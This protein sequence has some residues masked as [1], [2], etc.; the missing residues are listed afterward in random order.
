MRKPKKGEVK[1]YK[2][3]CVASY[4][5]ENAEVAEYAPNVEDFYYSDH[6]GVWYLVFK[7]GEDMEFDTKQEMMDWI[8][9]DSS[10]I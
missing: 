6:I 5:Q 3:S 4:E 10:G 8:K 2:N 7:D 9:A 1:I